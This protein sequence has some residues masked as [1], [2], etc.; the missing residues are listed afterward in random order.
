MS[1]EINNDDRYERRVEMRRKRRQASRVFSKEEV[2]YGKETDFTETESGILS[3]EDRGDF[4]DGQED[5][6]TGRNPKNSSFVEPVKPV[7]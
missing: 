5:Q 2:D 1:M 4:K 7:A 6:T 3:G